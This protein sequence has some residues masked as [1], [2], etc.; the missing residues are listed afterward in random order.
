MEETTRSLWYRVELD[1]STPF[2]FACATDPYEIPFIGNGSDDRPF[3]IGVTTKR[4]I[5][6]LVRA[7]EFPFHI[8]G[9]YKV[10]QQ[11]YPMV[12]CGVSD[13]SRSIHIAAV[14]ISSQMRQEQF[15]TISTSIFNIYQLVTGEALQ[16]KHVAGDADDAQFNGFDEIVTRN[17]PSATY[18]MCFF[19]VM[20]NVKKRVRTMSDQERRLVYKHAYRI[21]HSRDEVSAATAVAAAIEAWQ[22]NTQLKEFSVY[23]QREWIN[24]RF[25]RWLCFESATGLAKT[26]NPL[27]HFNKAFKRDYTQ[28]QVLP[29]NGLMEKVKL[30][31]KTKLTAL[32][33][34][35]TTSVVTADLPR[36]LKYLTRAGL[37]SHMRVQRASV[38]WMLSGATSEKEIRPWARS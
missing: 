32:Q 3:L 31:C 12:V 37:V 30:L 7:A 9:T 29:I 15:A 38:N 8:D 34:F 14:F 36:R 19:H 13:A 27:E 35:K 17:C 24:S 25:D 10:N 28:R 20:Q 16:I 1:E 21:H 33:E 5:R 11:A 4:L 23:F 22:V 18:L 2:M 26:D 6:G